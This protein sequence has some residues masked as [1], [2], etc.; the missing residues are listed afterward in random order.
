L[1]SSSWPLQDWR[2]LIRLNEKQPIGWSHQAEWE[3]AN[4]DE[5]T[6]QAG[7]ETADLGETAVLCALNQDEAVSSGWMRNS[8]SGWSCLVRLDEKQLRM[9][10]S[11]CLIRLNVKQPIRMKLPHQAGW[12]TADLGEIAVLC[13]L[14]QDEAVSS[15]WMRNSQ[16]GW[17]CLIRLDEKET[18]DLGEIGVLCTLNQDEAV[19]S[20]WMRNSQ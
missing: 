6:Y 11:S 7:W 5:A 9:K 10:L 4:Q 13:A 14:N 2:C 16:S 18:A 19:S 15:G 1:F 12:E 8:Q 20:G 3:T 17:S